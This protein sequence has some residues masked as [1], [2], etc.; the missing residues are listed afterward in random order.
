MFAF[1]WG[2]GYADVDFSGLYIERL[3]R[4]QRVADS[5]DFWMVGKQEAIR[6]LPDRP[7]LAQNPVA[8]LP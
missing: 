5:V 1:A 7:S 6:L 2:M 4:H 8:T 3:I